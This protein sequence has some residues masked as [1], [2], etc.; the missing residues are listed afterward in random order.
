[1]QIERN[2]ELRIVLKSLTKMAACLGPL[3]LT[4][5]LAFL[6]SEDYLSFGGGCKDII[7]LIPWL[8]WSAA[9]VL[10]FIGLWIKKHSFGWLVGYSAAG[11]TGVVALAWIILLV[12]SLS[13]VLT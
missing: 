11:A 7:L 8:V 1:V 5:L 13:G 9:Y 4:P 2:R 3:A 6:I 10:I 12:V